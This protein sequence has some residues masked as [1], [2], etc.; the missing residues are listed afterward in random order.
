MVEKEKFENFKK[1]WNVLYKPQNMQ[2]PNVR[3]PGHSPIE[4]RELN[5]S[6]LHILRE[7]LDKI[8]WSCNYRFD[9]NIANY[10]ISVKI[11]FLANKIIQRRI[12]RLPK[13]VM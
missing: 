8:G 2:G 3:N 13:A 9:P 7:M 5:R 11:P 12:D 6:S 1:H 10:R 4:M